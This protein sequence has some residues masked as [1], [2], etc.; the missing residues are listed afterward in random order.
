MYLMFLQGRGPGAGS[1]RE[2]EAVAEARL[3]AGVPR[4][5]IVNVGANEGQWASA[6]MP[7]IPRAR[8]VL[9]EPSAQCQ[10]AL[11]ALREAR[12]SGEVEVRE[13]ALGAAA[14]SA[15][16]WADAP[17]SPAA[18]VFQRPDGYLHDLTATMERVPV[19]TLDELASELGLS[20]IDLLKMD[21]EGSEFAVLSGASGLLARGQIRAISFEFGSAAVAARVFFHDFW[22]LL[23]VTGG[24]RISRVL[25]G[26]RTVAIDEYHERLE[27]FYGT[28]TYL[29]TLW[30][31]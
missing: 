8:W 14:G 28:A 17:G 5:V 6:M 7:R 31:Q 19:T 24:Y 20:R 16:V 21:C 26:G 18:S 13:V 15:E 22:E 29:A 27:H 30:G 11:V 1:D 4:P 10:Q 25:P 3:L 12:L 2:S 9:V 23:A